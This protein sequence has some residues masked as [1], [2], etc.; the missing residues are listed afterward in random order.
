[1]ALTAAVAFQIYAVSTC[2]P[3]GLV[4]TY[5]AALALGNCIFAWSWWR[6][7]HNKFLDYRA[8]AEGLRVRLFWRI[9]GLKDAVADHYLRKQR[10][11]LDWIR[12]A[13]RVWS[14]T[15]AVGDLPSSPDELRLRLVLNGWVQHQE[16]YYSRVGTR[17]A[18]RG[19]VLG[20]CGYAFLVVGLVLAIIKVFMAA[21]NPL[22]VAVSLAMVV[23]ALVHI[24]K[25]TRAFSEHA[26]QYQ[27]MRMTFG[28]AEKQFSRYLRDSDISGV[29]RL[30]RELGEEALAENGDWVLLHRERPPEIG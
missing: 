18:K 29:K 14:M 3:T 26:K 23:A 28:Q 27:R 9:A 5:L 21:A 10:G 12:Q 15:P 30:L 7:Y 11:E 13:L 2:Q 24:Y 19:Q 1:L 17:D 25:Q 22:L 16:Q 6:D 8:L 4:V 20:W